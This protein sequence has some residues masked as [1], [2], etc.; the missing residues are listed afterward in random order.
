MFKKVLTIMLVLIGMVTLAACG[1]TETPVDPVDELTTLEK[2]SEAMDQ[3]DLPGSASS[4]LTLVTSGLHDVVISWSSDNTDVIANDGTVTMPLF[5]DGDQTVTLTASLTLDGETLTKTFEIDVDAATEMSDQEKADLAAVAFN[6][7]YSGAQVAD[8]TLPATG[9]HGTTVTWA[10]DNTDV[11][12]NDGM[13]TRPS[14]E[15]GNVVVHLTGTVTSGTATATVVLTVTITAEGE[16][17]TY[18]SIAAIYASAVLD[19]EIE[20]T[21]IVTSTFNGGYFLTD[22]TD[23]LGI[24]AGNNDFVVAKGDEVKVKGSYAVYNSLYQLGSISQKEILS[25]GNDIVITPMETTIAGLLALDS[26]DKTIHGKY[27]TVTGTVGLFGDYDNVVL[28]DGADQVMV[29]Y[30]SD[31]TSLAALEAEVG[32]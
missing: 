17:N 28:I 23:V 11:V 26:T 29:Y 18:A 32:K 10:S 13:V 2:I 15:D 1:N 9:L 21:G 22:G 12:T 31:P 8:F 16:V 6:G 5:T 30:Q 3:L 25:S 7:L 14:F 27:Y 4:N 24:Y 20:F 19:E